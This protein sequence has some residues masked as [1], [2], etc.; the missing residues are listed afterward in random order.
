MMLLPHEFAVIT[1]DD[2]R[3]LLAALLELAG[4]D[5]NRVAR[6]LHAAGAQAALAS[7]EGLAKG[8]TLAHEVPPPAEAPKGSAVP[9]T[10][11]VHQE[12]EMLGIKPTTATRWVQMG[13]M[14]A[15]VGPSPQR[16]LWKKDVFD[17]WVRNGCPRLRVV[18]RRGD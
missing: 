11:N 15:P 7:L 17:V 14:P 5:R 9:G 4:G 18:K 3:K 12:C 1:A 8:V 10:Y 16:K 13:K 6:A 2:A